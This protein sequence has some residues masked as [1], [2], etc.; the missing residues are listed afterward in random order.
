MPTT[1]DVKEML[2]SAVHFGHKT[3]KWHPKMSKFI[4]GAREG[5]HIID[6][7][8]TK[9][10]LEKAMDFLA[11]L[12]K[13][14][15][16]ILFVGTK[17]QAAHLVADAC[18][19]A[20]VSYVTSKWISGLLTNFST[21][22]VRIKYLNKL[23]EEEKTGELGKYTKKEISQFKKIAAKL[24]E[25][26]GGVGNMT[27]LPDAVVVLDAV[28]D[29]IAIKEAAKLKIPVVAIC[30]TNANPTGVTYVIP[31]N[32]DSIKSIEYFVNELVGAVKAAR[33]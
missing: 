28:R 31:G 24:Q 9:Q 32:D 26:L 27:D 16:N 3:A 5:I 18:Q 11:S 17:A 23:K 8:K 12:T 4:F 19:S 22:K 33:K 7:Y 13:D 29:R 15:K 10:A 1:V 25:S 2:S 20:G 21:V 6:L 30:D 14:G